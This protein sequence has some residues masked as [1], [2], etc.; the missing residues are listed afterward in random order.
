M[1]SSSSSPVTLNDNDNVLANINVNLLLVIITAILV[2]TPQL[3]NVGKRFTP[4][5]GLNAKNFC[6]HLCSSVKLERQQQLLGSILQHQ[7][8]VE[9][10]GNIV[11]ISS[12]PQRQRQLEIWPLNV[13][14]L[15][16]S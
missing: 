7:P 6:W 9:I 4:L 15:I 5:P 2:F 11:L 3:K 14:V 12:H 13:N 10:L 1:A 8:P 16:F